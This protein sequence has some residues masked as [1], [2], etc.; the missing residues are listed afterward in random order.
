MNAQ[1]TEPAVVLPRRISRRLERLHELERE[2]AQ[3]V[4]CAPT[5]PAPPPTPLLQVCR[6]V[7][8]LES[9]GVIGGVK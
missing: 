1:I 6:H 2:I 3:V 4:R 5:I 7:H 9:T 8:R